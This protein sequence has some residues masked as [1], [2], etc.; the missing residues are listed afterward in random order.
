MVFEI[1]RIS[2]GSSNLVSV[3]L[4]SEVRVL[5]WFGSS[6]LD[7]SHE[8]ETT[9]RYVRIVIIVILLLSVVVVQ[10]AD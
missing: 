1:C 7:I 5:S 6:A 2:L 8:L 9:A 10:V 4:V 3:E